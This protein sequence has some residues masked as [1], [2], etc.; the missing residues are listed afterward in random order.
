MKGSR[1]LGDENEVVISYE[2]NNEVW[3][4]RVLD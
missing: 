1:I 2:L 4:M 3:D